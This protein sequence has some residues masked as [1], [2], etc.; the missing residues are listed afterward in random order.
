MRDLEPKVLLV[1]PP[2]LDTALEAASQAGIPKD[3]IFQFSDEPTAP[4][5]GIADWL[6]MLGTSWEG[7]R[8]RWPDLSPQESRTTIA[9]VNFSSGTT[10]LPKGVCITHANLIANVEQSLFMLYA[11]TATPYSQ[12]G[13]AAPPPSFRPPPERHVGMLPLYHAFGQ[14][15]ILFI[16]LRLGQPV[17]I[18]PTFHYEAFLAVVARHRVTMLQVPPPVLAMLCKR[19]ETSRYDLGSLRRMVV[20]AAPLSRELQNEAQRRFGV[21]ISQGWGMTEATCA[22]LLVPGGLRDESGSVG[23]LAPGTEARI[24]DE[25]DDGEKTTTVVAVVAPAGGQG[26]E[27]GHGRVR[28]GELLVRGPQ[29]CLG[30]WRNARATKETLTEDGWLRTGDVV[31]V[32][33]K[34]WFWVV[35]RKKELIKVNALQ[36][37][38]AELEKLLLENEHISDAAVVGITV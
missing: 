13:A 15:W 8:Y 32:D 36:V 10:G 1:Q 3:H 17:Y 34:G 2:F 29:V 6:A 5:N 16:A 24:V 37:A 30:Y 22:G 31:E 35:D 27:K 7:E 4:R 28:R 18:M 38:P 12:Q 11:E 25:D 33:T 19:P 23:V 26:E 14:S 20:G 21:Q 9:T